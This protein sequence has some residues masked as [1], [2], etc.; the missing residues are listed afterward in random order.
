[1]GVRT[2][3]LV[4]LPLLAWG[5]TKLTGDGEGTS[6][7]YLK[8]KDTFEDCVL[9]VRNHRPTANGVTWS[10]TTNKCYAEY[11]MT[12]SNGNTAW[13]TCLLT[14]AEMQ[15]NGGQIVC[16]CTSAAQ[17]GSSSSCGSSCVTTTNSQ[18]LGSFVPNIPFDPT[19]EFEKDWEA[20]SNPTQIR[21]MSGK[22][23]CQAASMSG[24]VP[25]DIECHEDDRELRVTWDWGEGTVAVPVKRTTVNV[26]D[27]TTLVATKIIGQRI[28]S[29]IADKEQ[30]D[31]HASESIDD[32][33]TTAG[34]GWA[35]NAQPPATGVY[36]LAGPE[37]ISSV[38]ILSGVGR[39]DHHVNDFELAYTADPTPGL[40]STWTNVPNPTIDASFGAT[41]NAGRITLP[42]TEHLV[43]GFDTITAT[44]VRIIIR[45]SDASNDNSVLTEF[46]IGAAESQ[47]GEA[48]FTGLGKDKPYTV[49]ITTEYAAESGTFPPT[50]TQ[51]A[52]TCQIET[53]PAP[54]A[55]TPRACSAAP[56][57][58]ANIPSGA[59]TCKTIKA[60][61]P[62]AA[63]AFYPIDPEGDG[64]YV[65]AYCDMDTDGGGWTLA[66]SQM[67]GLFTADIETYT[68]VTPATDTSG[69]L[70]YYLHADLTCVVSEVRVHNNKGQ[71]YTYDMTR[72]SG[73]GG[74]LVL[75]DDNLIMSYTDDKHIGVISGDHYPV[76]YHYDVSCGYRSATYPGNSCTNGNPCWGTTGCGQSYSHGGL[77]VWD[78]NTNN[79]VAQTN[80]RA[81]F[82]GTTNI[83]RTWAARGTYLWVR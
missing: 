39:T 22:W 28:E 79:C 5:C 26:Y 8:D 72:F 43:V 19:S 76:L 82:G 15:N 41:I 68:G 14:A 71:S 63:T 61:T 2:L 9:Y 31:Y 21:G 33:Y 17:S 60:A 37:S 53:C 55:A 54:T 70:G 59:K 35:Y 24:P 40:T 51:V 47:I 32:V 62:N 81:H 34:N 74:A 80:N 52:T 44:G 11:G 78:F 83:E 58:S 73:W 12:G 45:G 66:I 57:D 75:N 64:T 38:S 36:V 10:P 13:E 30:G 46:F 29:I 49:K 20:T 7:E 18:P 69:A 27:G 3:F 16:S 4:T 42:G 25:E 23:V 6:E 77:S 56:G 1:M 67:N 65:N 50:T 48:V